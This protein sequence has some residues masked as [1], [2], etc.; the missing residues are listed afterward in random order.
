MKKTLKPIIHLGTMLLAAI[1]FLVCSAAPS[2]SANVNEASSNVWSDYNI[3]LYGKIKVDVNYDTA[4]FS[5]TK[6]FDFMWPVAEGAGHKNDSSN[7]NP[8]DT[9]FGLIAS[10]TYGDW[11][12]KGRIET[13][14]YGSNEGDNLI[15][16]MRLAYIELKDTAGTDIRVGQDYI[17]V[18]ELFPSTIDF[19]IL[20][21]CGNLWWRVPQVTVR[22]DIGNFQVLASVMK[23][24]RT[25]TYADD[26]MPWLLA[27]VQYE[28]GAIGKGNMIALGGG[29]RH[30]N[31]GTYDDGLLTANDTN[32]KNTDRW[33]VCAE[34]KFHY[35]AFLIKGEL[36]T[37]QGIGRNFLRY[38]LGLAND[39]SP[40]RA[41]GGWADITYSI[42]SKSTV[43]AGY[44]FDNP[45][46]NDI[47]GWTNNLRFT[48]NEQY[49]LNTWYTLAKPLKVGAEWIH[50]ETERYQ[51]IDTGN[52]FTVSMQY[53]F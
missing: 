22:Q 32:C 43:T 9:R 27:R 12:V 42:N 40:A 2:F 45:N 52:R 33:L 16:R 35:N 49:Y 6:N 41:T 31:Y 11:T 36:W 21:A 37:G 7:F 13:D 28:G 34:A 3:K 1:A 26:T 25:S 39:G 15:P 8:R 24:R 18:S 4:V 30:A 51:E 20:S 48:K 29:Y 10:H 47:G 17:P 14:F 38:D 5:G 19:G 23:H 44:G 53:V 46:N 50:E